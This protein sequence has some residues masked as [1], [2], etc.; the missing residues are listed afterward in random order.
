LELQ[1]FR[2]YDDGVKQID[3]PFITDANFVVI[4]DEV[5]KF[6][7]KSKEIAMARLLFTVI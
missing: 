2:D 6:L 4:D 5:P 1:L 7:P 3:E